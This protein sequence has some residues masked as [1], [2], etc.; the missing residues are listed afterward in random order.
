MEILKKANNIESASNNIVAT[1]KSRSN[2][3]EDDIKDNIEDKNNF[4]EIINYNKIKKWIYLA[5]GMSQNPM[6]EPILIESFKKDTENRLC[7]YEALTLMSIFEKSLEF[8]HQTFLNEPDL[9]AAENYSFLLAESSFENSVISLLTKYDSASYSERKKIDMFIEKSK[10]KFPGKV[11]MHVKKN[12]NPQNRVFFSLISNLDKD[13]RTT[14][15]LPYI[16][17]RDHETRIKAL[18]ML[19]NTDDS[20]LIIKLFEKID[21]HELTHETE[22]QALVEIFN[23][24]DKTSQIKETLLLMDIN[25][26]KI[27]NNWLNNADHDVVHHAVQIQNGIKEDNLKKFGISLSIEEEKEIIKT[28][29]IKDLL[30]IPYFRLIKVTGNIMGIPYG[31]I[32]SSTEITDLKSLIITVKEYLNSSEK[33]DKKSLEIWFRRNCIKN[34]G[35]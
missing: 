34:S 3:S 13:L 29:E 17:T 27:L 16:D 6:A 22:Q 18:K 8:T 11:I 28:H 14:I 21:N 15:L 23:K 20:R 33:M 24:Y 1:S 30:N 2:N 4:K 9:A 10:N 19:N 5:L 26:Y 7:I 35:L 12:I 31:I 25:D 32:E